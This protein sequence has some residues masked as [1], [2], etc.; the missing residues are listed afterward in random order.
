MLHELK[1]FLETRAPGPIN[2]EDKARLEELLFRAWPMLPG[3]DEGGMEA[4]KL[5]GRT[6]IPG[7]NPPVLSFRIERHPGTVHGSTRGELQF[8]EVNV[9]Q[10]QAHIA[11]TTPK[12]LRKM[13]PRLDVVPIAQDISSAICGNVEHKHLKWLEAGKRVRVIDMATLIPANNQQTASS[14][15]R[16]F[17]EKLDAN[18]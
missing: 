13:S 8:W 3:A 2:T 4:R 9:H 7:W 10:P 5:A 16:R 11:R 1:Q 14:R 15:R 18:L 17:R 6:E 12:Q